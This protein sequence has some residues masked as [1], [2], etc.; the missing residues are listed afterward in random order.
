[1]TPKRQGTNC[2]T[3]KSCGFSLHTQGASSFSGRGKRWFLSFVLFLFFYTSF[4]FLPKC[5]IN[6]FDYFLKSRIQKVFSCTK[7][8]LRHLPII[9][10]C[11]LEVSYANA[12]NVC[13][14]YAPASWEMTQWG[15][16]FMFLGAEGKT[17]TLAFSC[18]QKFLYWCHL[19]YKSSS[20]F[21]VEWKSS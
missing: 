5:M 11:S 2:V 1:M 17:S 18:L 10:S 9:G 13:S 4:Q 14:R 6:I 16:P 7:L 20:S 3:Q 12:I 8:W 21:W 19:N 15:H